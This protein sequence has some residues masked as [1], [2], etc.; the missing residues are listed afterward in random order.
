MTSPDKK[1]NIFETVDPLNNIV[2]LTNERWHTHIIFRHPEM[3]GEELLVKKSVEEPDSI[4]PDKN[5]PSDSIYFYEHNDDILK[6]YGKYL[7]VVVDRESRGSIKT[8]YVSFNSKIDTT[9]EYI[10]K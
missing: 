3:T 7:K 8:A 6:T 2:Y 4:Y 1:R 10:K 5:R 9:P